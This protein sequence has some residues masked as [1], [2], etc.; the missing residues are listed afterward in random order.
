MGSLKSFA[1]KQ[2]AT[3]TWVCVLRTGYSSRFFVTAHRLY[4]HVPDS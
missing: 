2:L 4:N 3:P 1:T